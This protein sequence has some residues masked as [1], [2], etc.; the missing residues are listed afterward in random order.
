VLVLKSEFIGQFLFHHD[1]NIKMAALS[2]LI[3]APSTTKPLSSGAIRVIIKSLPSL[4]AE[5]DPGSRGEILSLVRGLL[6]RL[7]GGV[8]ANKENPVTYKTANKK[9][10]P[11]FERDDNE[12]EACMKD[13]MEFLTADLRPTASYH[14]HSMALKTILLLLESGIDERYSGAVSNK[15]EHR[16]IKWKFHLEIFGPRLERLLV[17]LLLDPFDEVRST[18]L[19]LLKLFPKDVLFGGVR[20]TAEKPELLIA[21]DKAGQLASNT[22]RADHADTVARLYSV[23]FF[24]ADSR[25][26]GEINWW[27]TRMGVVGTILQKLE[28]KLSS[29]EGL[30]NSALRDAPL[31]GY[32]CALR[33]KPVVYVAKYYTNQTAGILSLHQTSTRLLLAKAPLALRTG[34]QS[35]IKSRSFVIGSGTK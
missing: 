13:Y 32:L 5:S 4:H 9:L 14:R 12:T 30:F 29:P 20:Q 1:F 28:D 6:I 25:E 35:T 11:I 33:Y 18:A 19:H 31:H 2:L 16:D 21:L 34:D 23:I 26:P 24:T 17:D 10:V 7:K 8:L 3:M 15:P 27:D 22:S